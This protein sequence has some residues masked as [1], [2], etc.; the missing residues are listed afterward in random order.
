[1]VD[2][3]LTVLVPVGVSSQFAVQD[4]VFARKETC[5]PFAVVGSDT[6]PSGIFG[7]TP[8]IL[9]DEEVTIVTRQA[10]NRKDVL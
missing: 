5:L 9:V 3:R 1:M 2:G 6:H 8:I 7:T 4:D 10:G